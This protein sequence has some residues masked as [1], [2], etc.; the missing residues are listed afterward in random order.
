MKV[1][2]ICNDYFGGKFYDILFSELE[3][4]EIQSTVI[5]FLRNDQVRLLD[6]SQIN[7]KPENVLFFRLNWFYSTIGR[8]L[9]HLRNMYLIKRIRIICDLKEFSLIHAHTA[10]S[11]GSLALQINRSY[12]LPY[13]ISVRNTDINTV[14]L[15]LNFYKKLFDKIINKS[16]LIIFPAPAYTKKLMRRIN[17]N[18]SLL[19]KKSI[20]LPN[21]LNDYWIQNIGKP[22]SIDKRNVIRILYVGEISENKNIEFL[23]EVFSVDWLE[24]ISFEVTLVGRKKSNRPGL[25]YYEKLSKTVQAYSNAVLLEEINDLEQ[26]RKQYLKA[27]I[28]FMASKHETFGLVFIESIS[29]GTPVIYTRGEGID[30]YFKDGE[31]GYAITPSDVNEARQKIEL[32]LKNYIG[33]SK[34]CIEKSLDFNKRNVVNKYVS[35]YQKVIHS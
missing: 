7:L 1:L 23:L 18:E 3:N 34:R 6:S 8:V 4:N 20:I 12:N 32:I 25:K 11:N 16:S 31:I 33:L 35:S 19:T 29:Q 22:K 14:L 2:Q 27:D 17:T 24:S 21:P 13:I 15:K 28:F 10:F 26:L 5:V 9:P 30:G